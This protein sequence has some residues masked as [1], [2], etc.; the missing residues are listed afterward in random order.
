MDTCDD[1][2]LHIRGQYLIFLRSSDGTNIVPLGYFLHKGNN[3][4]TSS[5]VQTACRLIQEEDLGRSNELTRNTNSAFLPTTDAF[6]D[7]SSNDT[8]CLLP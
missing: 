4:E 1:N 3:L 7:R 5:R 2:Q 6:S 8:V